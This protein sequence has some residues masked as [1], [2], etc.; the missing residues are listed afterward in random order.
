VFVQLGWGTVLRTHHKVGLQWAQG[1][2]LD[3]NIRLEGPKTFPAAPTLNPIGP[4]TPQ[5]QE[6]IRLKRTIHKT[7]QQNTITRQSQKENH[8]RSNRRIYLFLAQAMDGTIF[9]PL[10]ALASKQ[11]A[12]TEATMEK[13]LQFLDNAES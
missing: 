7:N 11:A 6:D 5:H 2:P 4:A 10:G 3:A 12:P 8:S 9:P 1:A 13:C